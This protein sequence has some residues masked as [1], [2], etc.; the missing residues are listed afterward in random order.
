MAELVLDAS[1]LTDLLLANDRG[2]AVRW[3]VAG[4]VLHAPSH[5][6]AEVMHALGR[7][8]DAGDLGDSDVA[9]RMAALVAAPIERHLVHEL[10]LGAW[11]R[12]HRLGLADALY[13]EL[14]TTRGWPLV[15][16]DGRLHDVPGVEVVV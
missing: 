5:L 1:A 10:V 9:T 3:R 12:R 2:E 13:V 7:L 4:H 15:T 16:T 6:D 8:H 14:A 11:S